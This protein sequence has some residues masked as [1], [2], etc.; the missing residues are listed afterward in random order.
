MLENTVL[1]FDVPLR[2]CLAP[3][4]LH[5]L[6]LGTC[7]VTDNMLESVATHSGSTL[8]RFGIG[9]YSVPSHCVG[10]NALNNSL[11][12]CTSGLEALALLNIRSVVFHRV[13]QHALQRHRDTLRVVKVPNMRCSYAVDYSSF[14]KLRVL[15]IT[16]HRKA[17]RSI[18]PTL[19]KLVYWGAQRQE[20]GSH[21]GRNR[22]PFLTLIEVS[23]S[24]PENPRKRTNRIH[25]STEKYNN[26]PVFE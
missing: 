1:D 21:C 19:E 3:F 25:C 7:Q 4:H 14:C 6:H 9:G 12:A 5:T 22:N 20:M 17:P 8:K 13:E 26:T 24:P 11:N 23:P 10:A 16:G 2:A 15:D 18:P